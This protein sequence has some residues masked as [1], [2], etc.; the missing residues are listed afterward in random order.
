[1]KFLYPSQSSSSYTLKIN[2]IS[3]LLE[4]HYLNLRVKYTAK[5]I[6]KLIQVGCSDEIWQAHVKEF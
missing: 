1:M 4:L 6:R 3:F 5:A 2:P